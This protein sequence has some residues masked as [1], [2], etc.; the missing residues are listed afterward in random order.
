M[1]LEEYRARLQRAEDR[2]LQHSIQ[3]VIDIFQ[4]SLFQALIGTYAPE[5]A[6][7]VLTGLACACVCPDRKLLSPRC[8]LIGLF[9][10]EDVFLVV[11]CAP[12]AACS[13]ISAAMGCRPLVPQDGALATVL[14]VA[15]HFPQQVLPVHAGTGSCDDLVD[16]SH[17]SKQSPRRRMPPPPPKNPRELCSGWS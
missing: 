7:Q 1:L 5:T 11:C 9:A 4:S 15:V 12:P 14:T 16:Q 8:L 17:V 2:Q 3:R 6:S 13:G 10:M